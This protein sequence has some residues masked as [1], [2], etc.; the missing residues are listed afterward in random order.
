MAQR[1]G[2]SRPHRRWYAMAKFNSANG[3]NSVEYYTVSVW[4]HPTARQ[5]RNAPGTTGFGVGETQIAVH[6]R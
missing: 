6:V 2:R 4:L 5:R 3:D 1:E